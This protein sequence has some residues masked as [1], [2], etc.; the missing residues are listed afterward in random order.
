MQTV[1]P[2]S[3]V[4][5]AHTILLVEDDSPIRSVVAELL[6]AEGYSVLEAGDGAQAIHLLDRHRRDGGLCL[7]LLDMNLPRVDGVGVLRHLAATGAHVPVV[8]ISAT[9]A[10]LGAARRQGVQATLSKPFDLDH[11]LA[12]V[13]HT[14]R[15]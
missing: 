12:V 10:N 8:A 1:A 3:A 7:V 15:D 2:S 6:D 4:A 9:E 11:L 5:T 13:A 14:C